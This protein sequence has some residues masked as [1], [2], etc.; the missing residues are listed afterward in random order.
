MEA[1]REAYKSLVDSLA[2]SMSVSPEDCEEGCVPVYV[3]MIGKPVLGTSTPLIANIQWS[4]G[5][6]CVKGKKTASSPIHPV[7]IYSPDEDPD[8]PMN[9][10]IDAKYGGYR[11]GEGGGSTTPSEPEKPCGDPQKKRHTVLVNGK[12]VEVE[13]HNPSSSGVVDNVIFPHVCCPHHEFVPSHVI[14]GQF[15]VAL[16]EIHTKALREAGR[17]L[18]SLADCPPADI[19]PNNITTVSIGPVY[20][21]GRVVTQK[22]ATNCDPDKDCYTVR[23]YVSCQWTVQRQCSE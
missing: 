11:L 2:G 7:R 4:K 6:C 13:C 17:A 21:S 14:E 16:R 22:N 19:C 9:R 12:P 18:I 15:I 20:A 3:I 23:I 5:E 10:L 8:D 1:I